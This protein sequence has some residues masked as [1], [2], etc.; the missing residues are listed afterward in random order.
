MPVRQ[1]PETIVNRIAAGEVVERPASVVKELVENA[2]DAGACRIEIFTDGGGRRRIAITDDGGGMTHADLDACRG[3]PRHLE[4]RRRGSAA[5]PHAWLPRRGAA[6]DRLGGAVEHHHA[7]RHRAACLVDASRRRRRS[8]RSSPGGAVA[9]HPRR[10]QRP[11]LR[12][13]GAAE[14]SQDRPHRGR[15][16]PRGGAPPRHGAAGHRLHHG[17]RGTRAGDLGGGAARSGRTADAAR[18]H[19]RSRVSPQRHRS[20]QRTRGRAWSK[21]LPRHRR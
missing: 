9:G 4:A 21:A 14:I 11:V 2:I 3:P 17:R 8:R 12:D 16:D 20:A 18:R 19:S 6:V 15:S 10:G 1:L 7:P 5:D 13:A